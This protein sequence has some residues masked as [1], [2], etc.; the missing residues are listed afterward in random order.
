ML[1]RDWL[2]AFASIGVL[3]D[4]KDWIP[5][6]AG[7]FFQ[8]PPV[9]WIVTANHVIKDAGKHSIAILVG[10]QT[11]KIAT[12]NI[13]SI[14]SKFKF[15]WIRDEEGD[16]AASVVPLLPELTIKAVTKKLCKKLKDISPSMSCYTV[17]CPYG[18]RGFEH[19]NPTPLVLDGIVAGVD[20]RK[21][22]IYTSAPTFP[23]N[24]GG[25][26][27][28][29][30]KPYDPSGK[31]MVIGRPTLLLGGI[32]IK[33][34]LVSEEESDLNKLPPLHLGLVTPSDRILKLL[35]SEKAKSIIKKLSSIHTKQNK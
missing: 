35:G 31:N 25:P 23:G 15:G 33:W 4:S 5:I 6:G 14:Q 11:E 21:G 12:V 26:L 13:T 30:E 22:I 7:V 27:V 9:I 24:S 3:K 19:E 34:C 2:S 16:L 20:S 17:G 1:N 28:V 10:H 32:V 18:I 29:E 8:T